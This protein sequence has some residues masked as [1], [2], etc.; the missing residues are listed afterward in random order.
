MIE[1]VAIILGVVVVALWRTARQKDE[2]YQKEWRE[3]MEAQKEI[4]R[5]QTEIQRLQIKHNDF[6]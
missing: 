3:H 5:L 2:D 1:T 6:S 4:G